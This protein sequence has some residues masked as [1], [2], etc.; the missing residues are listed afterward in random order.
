MLDA[1]LRGPRARFAELMADP[2]ELERVLAAGA[3]R[4]RALVS[5]TVAR[6]RAAVGI[7]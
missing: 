1:A 7:A 4:A 3:E 5:V 6:M 2:G